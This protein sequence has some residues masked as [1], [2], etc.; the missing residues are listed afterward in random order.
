MSLKPEIIGDCLLYHGDTMEILPQLISEGVDAD[1]LVCDPPYELTSGGCTKGG[2]HERFGNGKGN[3]GNSGNLFGDDIPDW[4]EFMPLFHDCLKARAH[5]YTMADGKNQLPMQNESLAAGFRH[6]NLL[7]WNKVTATPNKYYMKNDEFILFA[8]KG[9]AR[10][11]NECG[12]MC[13]I[14]MPHKDEAPHPTEKPVSLMEYYIK[15]SS[16]PSEVVIDPFMGVGTTGVAAVNTQRKFIGIERDAQWFDLAC[17]R[18]QR[19]VDQFQYSL[20]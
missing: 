3:Y 18:I 19:A 2:L 1:M 13:G 4:S 6:H 20:F 16:K 9:K 10:T 8:F 5:C 11:I 17:E 12:S 14:T 15:N 7:R